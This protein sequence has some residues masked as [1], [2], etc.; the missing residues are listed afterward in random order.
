MTFSAAQYLTQHPNTE[1]I[2]RTREVPNSD[3]IYHEIEFYIH[4]GIKLHHVTQEIAKELESLKIKGLKVEP[5]YFDSKE[6]I[7]CYYEL[8]DPAKYAM[9]VYFNRIGLNKQKPVLY[10]ML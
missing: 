4:D 6:I 10:H 5:S 7:G 8:K 3:G 2:Y 1:I 9:T